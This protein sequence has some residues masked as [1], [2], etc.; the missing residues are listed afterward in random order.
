MSTWIPR[1]MTE[2]S[3]D[4]SQIR[5]M[6]AIHSTT[7]FS[8]LI[9]YCIQ[10]LLHVYFTSSQ[11]FNNTPQNTSYQSPLSWILHYHSMNM[12]KLMAVTKK[13][14]KEVTDNNKEEAEAICKPM[15][16]DITLV[17]PIFQRLWDKWSKPLLICY[18][19]YNRKWTQY[20]HGL[21]MYIARSLLSARLIMFSLDIFTVV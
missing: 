16:T 4:A 17:V 8:Q 6:S 15:L 10:H 20:V 3:M 21:M 9:T 2:I 19:K 11:V 12:W 7:I 13:L 5:S 18:L 14:C 1:L